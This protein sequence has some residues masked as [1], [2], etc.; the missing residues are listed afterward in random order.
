MTEANQKHRKFLRLITQCDGFDAIPM[1]VVHPCDE[2]SI[3]GMAAAAR[4]KLIDP[5]LVG[6]SARIHAAAVSGW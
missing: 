5:I 4:M 1:A 6:P 3:E 2:N